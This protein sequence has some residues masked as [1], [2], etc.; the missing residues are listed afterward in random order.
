M[1]YENLNFD[2]NEQP[3]ESKFDQIGINDEALRLG[4]AQPDAAYGSR[5]LR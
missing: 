3:P 4:Q 2:P 5:V 1:P